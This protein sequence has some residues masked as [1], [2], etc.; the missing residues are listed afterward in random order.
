M[1]DLDIHID[2]IVAGD[3][4][5]FGQWVAGAEPRLRGGLRSFAAH[6]DTEAVLQ[7]AL[8]RAWQVA[9]R[10]EPDGRPDG[11]LRLTARIARNLALM[12]LR[13]ARVTPTEAEVLARLADA[14][15]PAPAPPD[16]L[17]RRLI[18]VCLEALP[19][20]PAAALRQRLA[21]VGSR[22]DQELADLAG[23]KLNTFLQ[24]IRRARLALE[25]CLDGKGVSLPTV[26]AP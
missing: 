1:S 25:A 21:S 22:H 10:F 4:R 19:A 18:Q 26:E 9:P 16:P 17:L 8:L 20:K 11:L 12:E 5:A 23:M 6:L 14:Q 7:E 13:R 2:A 24:N 15:A 3:A